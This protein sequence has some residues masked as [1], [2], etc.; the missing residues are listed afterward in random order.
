MVPKAMYDH[1]LQCT[2]CAPRAARPPLPAQSQ[3][4]PAQPSPAQPAHRAGGQAGGIPREGLAVWDS[5]G[6]VLGKR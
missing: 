1:T 3:P 5:A 2:S 6:R 4:G